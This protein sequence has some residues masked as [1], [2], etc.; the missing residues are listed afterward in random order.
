MMTWWFE[1]GIDGF[2]MDVINQ[3]SKDYPLMEQYR[4]GQD[5]LGKVIS[6]GPRVHEFLKEM[7]KEVLSKY[8]AMTVGETASVRTK[9]AIRYAGFDEN[10]LS[11]IFQFEHMSLDKRG[12]VKT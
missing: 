3:I 5:D 9:H 6:N 8:N 11:M 1:K 12:Y 4:K 2:R 7:N 10:E